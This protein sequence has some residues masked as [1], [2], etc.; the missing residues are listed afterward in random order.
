MAAPSGTVWGS[1]QNG[2][3]RIGIYTNVTSTDTTST[4]NVQV[5]FWTIYSCYDYNNALY[6][7]AGTNVTSATSSAGSFTIEHTIESGA[8]WNTANQTRLLNKTYSYTRGTAAVTYNVYA[9][10]ANVDLVGTT[11]SANTTY[12]VP[13]LASYTISYN[14]NGGSN[15]PAAQTKYYSKTLTLSTSKPTRTGY[16]FQ[17]WA[18]S[19]TGSVVYSAGG[20]YTADAA[21]TLYAVWKANTYP[22][23]YNANGGSDAPAAQT[24]TY[25]VALTLSSVIPTRTNYNFLGWGTT[26]SATTASYAP[27]A[28]YNANTAITLYAVWELAYVKPAIYNF[29][30]T[31]CDSAGAA[32]DDGF[33][34]LVE[35][36]WTTTNSDPT[37]TI[38]LSGE[39]E[40][41]FALSGTSGNVS[42]I[43][44]GQCDPDVSYTIVVTVDD[45]S[46]S[47]TVNATLSTSIYPIDGLAGGKG[48][49][50]G[51]SAELEDTAE[52]A[53]D[54]K[55]NK[56][57]YGKALGMDRLPEIPAGSE[58]NDY[59]DPGC[60][61][62]YTNAKAGTITADGALLGSSSTMPPDGAGRLEVWSATGEGIHSAAYSYLRQRYIVYSSPHAVWERDITRSSDNVW[63]YG[64][65][66]RSS[67]TPTASKK[68]Y[69]EQKTLW[70]GNLHMN[71]EQTIT[72]SEPIS[73]QAS[74]ITL[75]FS[76]YDNDAGTAKDHSINTFFL[77][78]TQIEL[79]P[80]CGHTFLMSINAGFS[81]VAAKYLLFTD[82]TITGHAG[83][84]SSGTNSGIAFN[85]ANYV[86]RYVIGV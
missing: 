34:A 26:A 18:T 36:E 67:L 46:G 68:A 66:W 41:S 65:W 33:Y 56:P 14:A 61:A 27:G 23:K 25:G 55:F 45:G 38:A 43:Y 54:A 42:K 22:V 63:T 60:W 37:V 2:N 12:T 29:S 13:A 70:S 15:A 1:I 35:F 31:R 57:V 69:H 20:S 28:T 47:T 64:D 52:F 77:S 4:V 53:F 40:E 58:L 48:V 62:I 74:G 16:T 72:L 83:N 59:I 10:F 24:K 79:F 21:A 30:V 71:G 39:G 19:S 73:E 85:N 32:S 9:K 8:G 76:Y 3:G 11:M 84:T 75:I 78:K 81:A 80:S 6:Y 86:L 17:G 82:T 7:N 51:K 50:F 49:A 44:G 5:W